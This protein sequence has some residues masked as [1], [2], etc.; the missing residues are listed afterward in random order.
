M[1]VTACGSQLLIAAH[2]GQLFIPCVSNTGRQS[3]SYL[4]M[5]QAERDATQ[6][7]VSKQQAEITH[8]SNTINGQKLTISESE[9]QVNYYHYSMYL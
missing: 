7:V 2:S 4:C 9:E 5:W 1:F 8:L 3:N 6:Q